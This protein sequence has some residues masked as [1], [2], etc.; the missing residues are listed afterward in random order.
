MDVYDIRYENLT[1]LLGE[2]RKSEGMTQIKFATLVGLGQAHVSQITNRRRRI[3]DEAA[4]RIEAAFGLNRGFLD[5]PTGED[6]VT[7]AVPTERRVPVMSWTDRLPPN[8]RTGDE[9]TIPTSAVASPL[10]YALQIQ[11]DD[12]YDVRAGTGIPPGAYVIID[13]ALPGDVGD[14]VVIRLRT[15]AVL[16]QIVVSAGVRYMKPL[17]PQ[18]P[19]EP[20]PRHA[21]HAGVAVRWEHGQ[22]IPH[23]HKR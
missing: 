13:P 19:I 20:M 11:G 23:S 2:V 21:V 9:L 8:K 4:R 17:N 16:R 5:H 7:T 6:A 12:T 15:G 1:R 3:G 18:Y 10:W 14:V 22:D